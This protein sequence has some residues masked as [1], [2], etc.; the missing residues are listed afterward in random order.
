MLTGKRGDYSQHDCQ[1]DR[2]LFVATHSVV[3]GATAPNSKVLEYHGC[4]R[5]LL[6]LLLFRCAGAVV[7]IGRIIVKR[8]KVVDHFLVFIES[9]QIVNRWILRGND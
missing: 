6:Q 7:V 3:P 1:H 9:L 4:S 8:G 2:E 5:G